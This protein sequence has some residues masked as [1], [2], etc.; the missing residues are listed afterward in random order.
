MCE[1]ISIGTT[2]AAIGTAASAGTAGVATAAAATPWLAYA[3]LGMTALSGLG[4][5][6]Q[7]TQ[8]QRAMADNAN[9]QAM[10]G[11]NRAMLADWQARDAIA[12]GEAAAEIKGM[13]GDQKMGTAIAALAAQ[14]TDMSGS[15][16]S[17]IGDI[18][19]ANKLDKLTIKSNAEREAYGFK[20]AAAESGSEAGFAAARAQALSDAAP[21]SIATSIIGTA[22]SVATKWY[23]L[24][25][26]GVFS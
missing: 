13:E 5:V 3:G 17:I 7:M 10:V 21:F 19:A 16:A 4:S 23:G 2:A 1:P 12:R 9:Y 15:P 6:W 22:G 24:K 18:S 11:R 25:R 14:G 8:Q 26:A 20:V